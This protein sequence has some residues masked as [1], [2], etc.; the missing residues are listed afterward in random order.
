MLYIINQKKPRTRQWTLLHKDSI[1]MIAQNSR[2][3][4]FHEKQSERIEEDIPY[5]SLESDFR[6]L[7]IIIHD[8]FNNALFSI[9]Q[10]RTS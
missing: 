6:N 2:I 9:G 3:Y 8:K 1:A 5:L 4:D 7:N 10:G